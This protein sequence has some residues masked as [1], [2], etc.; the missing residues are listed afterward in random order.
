MA[1]QGHKPGAS[2]MEEH[3]RVVVIGQAPFGEAV[4]K[5]LAGAGEQVV[6]VCAPATREGARPD[7]LRAAAESGGIEVIET[8]GLRNAETFERYA[9]WKPDLLVMAFVTDILREN[10]LA[11]PAQGAIQYHPSLLPRHRGNSAINWAIIWGETKTGLTIFWPDKGIDTG[12][13]LLQREVE[14]GPDDTTGSLY[15]NKLFPSGVE[16]MAESVRLVREGKAP[17]IAQDEWQA[18]YER[19]CRDEEARIDWSRPAGE[20][21]NLIRGCNPQPGAWTRRNGEVLKVFECERAEGSPEG[22]KPGQVLA[23]DDQGVALALPRAILRVKRFQAVGAAKV[24]A[25]QYA[26]E[27]GLK[28][29][30]VLGGDGS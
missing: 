27:T 2:R 14:I 6:G 19:P 17:R 12:P 13:V 20:T 10:V 23:V 21:Y 5:A 3:M 24:A 4:Y 29:G 25:P 7:P 16:A 26:Q 30:D 22:A 1:L 11:A 9:A 28:P 15:F 18:T 8:R